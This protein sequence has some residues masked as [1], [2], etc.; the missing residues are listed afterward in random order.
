LVVPR[1]HKRLSF[2]GPPRLTLSP[3]VEVSPSVSS[4]NEPSRGY[5]VI[6][7]VAAAAFL[8]LL[9]TLSPALRHLP[10]VRTID[11]GQLAILASSVA[12]GALIV[13]LSKPSRRKRDLLV[14]LAHLVLTLASFALFTISQSVENGALKGLLDEGQARQSA[15]LLASATLASCYSVARADS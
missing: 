7:W 5:S 11:Q 3:V 14:Q 2:F 4:R 15:V 13:E 1:I 12:A 6:S 10:L 8:P 9:F